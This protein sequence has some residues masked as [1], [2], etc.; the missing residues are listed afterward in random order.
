MIGKTN[1]LSGGGAIDLNFQVIASSN[2]QN[3][4][5]G[6][7]GLIWVQVDNMTDWI[8]SATQ[9]DSPSVGLVWFQT[10]TASS[11]AF[12]AL[13]DQIIMIYPLSAYYYD[14]SVWSQVIAES[15]QSGEWKTWKTYIFES[16]KGP[17][18]R[19]S[20][21][22]IYWQQASG[23]NAAFDIDLEKITTKIQ[24]TY[25]NEVAATLY[26]TSPSSMTANQI[27]YFDI[28]KITSGQVTCGLYPNTTINS[29][30][31]FAVS[32]S[33][34]HNDNAG[35]YLLSVEVPSTSNYKIGIYSTIQNSNQLTATASVYNIY[36][37]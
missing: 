21:N 24:D 7:E 30:T 34:T 32:S 36:Y 2:T 3:P 12:N 16:G 19:N 27:V 22:I 14:G 9:P 33:L 17:A 31:S 26:S 10:G 18:D 23:A 8:F 37:T 35:R 6:I 5:T 1:A 29:S 28:Y 25:N 4:P 15:Y 11:V 20:W 13:K